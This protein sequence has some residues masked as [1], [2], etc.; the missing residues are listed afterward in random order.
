MVELQQLPFTELKIDKSFISDLAYNQS[1]KHI[2]HSIINLG[3]NMGLSLVAEGV[4]TKDVVDILKK[5][6]CNI[7]QGYLISKP[8]SVVDFINW[9]GD[10]INEQG[11]FKD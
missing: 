6:G 8:I 3:Q 4:E 7:I 11:I 10:K 1:N 5:L 2:V 9:H